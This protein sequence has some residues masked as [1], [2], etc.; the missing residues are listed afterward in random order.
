MQL[1]NPKTNKRNILP[2]FVVATF[3]VHLIS[4]LVLM[5][6]WSMLQRF[7]NQQVQGF[8]QLVDGR[9][10]AVN[11]Q[12]YLERHPQT[13]QRMVG[14]TLTLM[15]TASEKQPPETVWQTTSQLLSDNLQQKLQSEITQ[16][17]PASNRNNTNTN[18][19]SLL[20]L[21]SISKP[22]KIA[23]GKWQ[24]DVIANRLVFTATNRS[25]EKISFNK[26]I[27]VQAIDNPK[28]V[29]P[30]APTPL[31]LAVHQLGEAKLEI[32]NICDIKDKNCN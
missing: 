9:A 32:Y 3:S 24:V 28:I 17:N 1:I 25:G 20:L 22:E 13:I 29:L 21:Q 30:A 27:L 14:E 4:F 16:T 31:N 26:K 10:I 19:E 15:F 8:V 18:I 6:H 11:S 7:S 2:I 12:E 5:F 23:E